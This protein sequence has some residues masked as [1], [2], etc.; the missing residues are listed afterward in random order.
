MSRFAP[1]LL[2]VVFASAACGGEERGD[3]ATREVAYKPA[4]QAPEPPQPQVRIVHRSVASMGTLFELTLAVGEESADV[5]QAARAAFDEIKRVE[6]LM[7][8]WQADSPLSRVNAAAGSASV[9][10]PAELLDLVESAVGISTLT[11]GKFDISFAAMGGLW[12]FKADRPRLPD[13]REIKRRLALIDYRAIRIDRAKSTLRLAKPGMRIALGAIAKGFGVDRA[14]AILRERG[15]KN[16]IVYGGGDL[17]ISGKKG[18][19]PWSVGIQ[20]PRSGSRYF[21]RLELPEGGAVVTSGDYEKFFILDGKRYHHIIDPATGFPAEGAVSVTVLAETAARADALA[22]GLF[23]LGPEEGM[24]LIEADPKLE[25]IIVDKA[26]AV[27]V[28]SGLKS[29]AQLSPI[30]RAGEGTP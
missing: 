20:D 9:R 27:K 16:F 30:K 17:F 14:A 21:V 24:R 28:S 5:D 15:F 13:R 2:T 4:T 12:N 29:R 3:N 8:T 11:K 19:R 18:E 26:L 1:L 10:V 23:V 7:T 22:T 6:Q 25:G